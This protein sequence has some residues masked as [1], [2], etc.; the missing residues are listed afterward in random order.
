MKNL[1]RKGLFITLIVLFVLIGISKVY[2]INLSQDGNQYYVNLPVSGIETLSLDG[3]ITSFKIYDDGGKNSRYSLNCNGGI[4]ISAPAG[5]TIK[6]VGEANLSRDGSIE[7][8]D[9][10][11]VYDGSSTSA[12]VLGRYINETIND[13]YKNQINCTSTGNTML[14]QL[15]DIENF[16]ACYDGLNATITITP[17]YHT[18]TFK[19]W[20]GTVLKTQTDVINGGSATAPSNPTREGY[21]FTGWDKVFNNVTSN[22]E[23]N[24]TYSKNKY[25]VTFKDWNGTVLKNQ[26]NVEHGTSAT[27]PSDPIRDGYNFTGWDK[28]F[29]NVTGNLEVN[30]TYTQ[31][32]SGIVD[33]V[34]NANNG[35]IIGVRNSGEDLKNLVGLTQQEIAALGDGLN[36]VMYFDINDIS[37]TVSDEDKALIDAAIGNEKQVGIYLDINLFKQIVDHNRIQV[38]ET[39]GKIRMSFEIPEALRKE[40]RTFYIV[41]VHNGEATILESTMDGNTIYF[42]T[43]QFSTYALA[44]SDTAAQANGEIANGQTNSISPKTGDNIIM[45]IALLALSIAGLTVS[46]IYY[47]RKK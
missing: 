35:I 30:A 1:I 47:N 18:V 19:D 32:V 28:A 9:H 8:R 42:E 10:V 6:I 44:Y 5:Y 46:E 40:G 17:T 13:F 3:T 39:N 15:V 16:V 24:A 27:A 38:N 23:V 21:T 31:K 33:K 7:N 34:I 41:R 22:L 37:D 25:T 14:V 26:E 29:N 12:T 36:L 2:A 45:Y 11:I 20:D 43:D 4:V